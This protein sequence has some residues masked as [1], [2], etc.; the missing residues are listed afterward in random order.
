MITKTLF[1]NY[2]GKEVYLYTLSNGEIKVGV[3]DFGA[4][5]N[6]IKLNTADGEKNILVGYDCVQGYINSNS[7]CGTTVGR[8][9]NRIAGASFTLNGKSYKVSANEGET[10]LHGGVEGFDKRFFHAEI[11]SDKLVLSLISPDGDMGFP[12]ELKFRVEF[13]L[14][15]SG[16]LIE[17]TAVSD[18]TT[19]FAPTCHAYFNMNGEGEV[20]GNLLQINADNYTP[21]D[22]KLI[23]L[24]TV[25]SVKG[26][27]LDF[28]SPKRIGKD[29]K[30]LGGKTYDH[31]FCLNG[32]HVATAKGEI[33]GIAMDVYSDML[34]VQFYVGKP[35]TF[36]GKGGGCGFCLEPQFYPNAINVDGFESPVINKDENKKHYIKFIFS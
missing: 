20:M 33:S 17:Y 13:T 5:L 27:P 22:E 10:C 26:T 34:G 14:N 30:G 18:G 21:V 15:G 19:L 32:N 25:E 11:I 4:T 12:A 9:S 36:N 3:L 1:D 28:T 6:F 35:A 31:N 23:P 24:G 29:L 8:V 2:N 7:Y 16:L